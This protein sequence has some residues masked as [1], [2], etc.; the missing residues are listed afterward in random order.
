MEQPPSHATSAAG[1]LRVEIVGA[2]GE[3]IPGF[4]L[5]GAGELIGNEI[6]GAA[7]WVEGVDLG[8]LEGRAVRLRFHLRD[9]DV[10]SWRFHRA[11][12][13]GNASAEQGR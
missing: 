10:Y 1:G 8:R 4:G 2:D 9:G 11:P 12:I 5:D 3:A 13:L 6:D 7:R